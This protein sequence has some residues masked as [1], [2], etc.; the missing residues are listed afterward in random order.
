MFF[1]AEEDGNSD[2]LSIDNATM[3]EI[4]NEIHVIKDKEI[5]IL[6]LLSTKGFVDLGGNWRAPT[7]CYL[8]INLHNDV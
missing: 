8:F 4:I 3:G 7:C 2:I 1:Y 5:K 6:R